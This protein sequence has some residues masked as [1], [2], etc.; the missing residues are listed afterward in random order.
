MR[1][2]MIA[3]LGFLSGAAV[4]YMKAPVRE[5]AS[6]QDDFH[7]Q[8]FVS[9]AQA[10]PS[11]VTPP[12]AKAIPVEIE[13]SDPAAEETKLID[14]LPRGM[15]FAPN[16]KAIPEDQYS[17]GK[18]LMRKNGFIFYRGKNSQGANGNVVYDQR[19]NT[20]HPLMATIKITSVDEAQRAENLRTWSEYHYNGDL[21]VQYV[22]STHED[23][24]DDFA[25]LK[26]S[27]AKVSL[28]IVQAVYQSR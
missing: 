4:Y 10:A 5:T 21:Q 28:E 2:N 11:Q 19:L 20:F 8:E 27:G 25:E 14:G 15:K 13:T 17:E 9:T 1:K 18:I 26:K 24:L 6:I 3:L 22:Q 12:L 7:Q 16:V 23:L